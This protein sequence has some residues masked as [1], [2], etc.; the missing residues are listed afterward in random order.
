MDKEAVLQLA[1]RLNID[2]IMSFGVDPGVVTAAFVAEKLGLPSL[3]SY[4][5]TCILQD[6]S[7]FRQFLIDYGF[8]VSHVRGYTKLEEAI[9][10]IDF[11]HCL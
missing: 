8:N 4:R 1:E 3:G 10:D 7:K 5:S 11:Y 9:A 2:G 6:K